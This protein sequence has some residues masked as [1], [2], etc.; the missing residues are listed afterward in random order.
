MPSPI[1]GLAGMLAFPLVFL[2]A[3]LLTARVRRIRPGIYCILLGFLAMLFGSYV[4]GMLG[5]EGLG[6][7][8]IANGSADMM[9]GA[10][11][12]LAGKDG[13]LLRYF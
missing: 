12:L 13:V 4:A 6:Y 5:K 1:Y 9:L 8:L 2:L 10:L 11:L 3:S 7:F